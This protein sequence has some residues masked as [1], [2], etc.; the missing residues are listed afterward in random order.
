[1]YVS[2]VYN[3]EIEDRFDAK[4]YNPKYLDNLRILKRKSRDES[5]WYTTLDEVS[6]KITTSAFY[7]AIALDYQTSGIPFLRV[8]NI[9]SLT[10]DKINLTYLSEETCDAIKSIAKLK[11]GDIVI[12]KGGTVGNVAIIPKW[13]NKCCISRDVISVHPKKSLQKIIEPGYVVAFLLTKFGGLQFER[14][15]TQQIQSHLTLKVV[16]KL[17]ILV[18]TEE[19]HRIAEMVYKAEENENKAL[20]AI[21]KAKNI[22]LNT[23]GIDMERIDDRKAYF[24]SSRDLSDAFTPKFYYPKYLETVKQM[25]RKFGTIP[26]SEVAKIDRGNEVGSENYKTSLNKEDSDI[27]FI[28]TSDIVN[29]EIDNYPDYYI[30]DGIYKEINQ[31][32]RPQDILFTK[33]GKIG[34]A[35]M[36][37]ESDQC[38]IAS[39][40]A[41]I[42]IKE[43]YKKDFDPYYVFL[44]LSTDVG[45][46]QAFQRVVI[47]STIPHLQSERFGEIAIPI[48]ADDKQEE[49]SN[50]VKE[51]FELKKERKDL[52]RKAKQEVEELI[53]KGG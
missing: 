24:I 53:D 41:K 3:T 2:K 28:R 47:A 18:P 50:L 4:Y 45:V 42:R 51:A 46:Y 14:V 11:P 37:V 22:F 23:I 20:L 8:S 6:S 40:I 9:K 29:Y 7:K 17:K 19:Q 10:I 48:L 39:G 26:L 27:P 43:E 33:D 35:A 52:I 44:V 16:K 25:K 15:K 49:I 1:M 5:F 36:I 34:L 32:L 38:I 13:M 12:S 21:E 30:S 31:D